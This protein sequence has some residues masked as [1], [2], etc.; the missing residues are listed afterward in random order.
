MGGT[1]RFQSYGGSGNKSFPLGNNARVMNTNIN[2]N[3]S[4]E[5]SQ[6]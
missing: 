2:C 5:L 3:I 6:G 4:L 1:R